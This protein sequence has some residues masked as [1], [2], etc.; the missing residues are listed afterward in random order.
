MKSYCKGLTITR[1]LV[2]AAY[3]DWTK[4]P[5]GKKNAW[6]VVGEYGSASN[7]VDLLTAE[8]ASRNLSFAPFKRYRKHDVRCGKT[9]DIAIADIKYQVAS[10]VAK[11]ILADFMHAKLGY[12][13]VAGIKGK[14]QMAARK[15]IRKWGREG[16]YHVKLDVRKCYGHITCG[17]VQSI[18]DRYVESEDVSYLVSCLLASCDHGVLEIGT[19]FSMMMANLVL[20]FGYHH[21][22]CLTKT[23]RGKTR[24]LVAHQIWYM[25]DVLL[26]GHDKRDLKRAVGSLDAFMTENLGL[27]LKPWKIARLNEAEMLDIAGFRCREG[28]ITLRRRLFASVRRAFIRFGK[29]KTI[30][31]ARRACSYFGWLK[32]SD[33]MKF[34]QK[35]GVTLL[36]RSARKLISKQG[37]RNACRQFAAQPL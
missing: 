37:R 25:D 33:S 10:Y 17:L 21:I 26:M 8:I 9:R 16:G 22:E 14:G 20:S 27:S 18:I 7:L 12:W 28:H 29:T 34:R 35:A 3:A 13:Q 36:V 30:A 32:H 19:F 1:D 6:R 5:A 15:A 2:K 23:R 31:L 4:A 11:L 24:P